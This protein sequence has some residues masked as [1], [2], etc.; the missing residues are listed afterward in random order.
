MKAVKVDEA[1][2]VQLPMLTP[3]D[4]FTPHSV[5]ANDILLRKVSEPPRKTK[6][7]VLAALD[8]SPIRFTAG[9]DELKTTL[10]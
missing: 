4:C 6:A 3:G 9:W 8:E 2:R 7:E 5:G 1:R 10:R